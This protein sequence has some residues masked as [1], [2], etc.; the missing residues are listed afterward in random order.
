MSH[1]VPAAFIFLAALLSAKA[2]PVTIVLTGDSTVNEQGGWGTGFCAAASRQIR[3]INLALN[4][5]SSKSFRDEGRWAPV[6]A[7]KPNYVLIQFGHNDQ[8][9]KGPARETDPSTTYRANLERYIDEVRGV[10]GTPVLVTSIVRRNFDTAGRIKRDHL[11]PYV[12]AV[13][14]LA[15]KRKVPLI[16]LYALT[17]EQSEKLGPSGSAALGVMGADGKLDTTH[18]GPK[19]QQEIG[20]MAVREF[21]RLHPNL[22][23]QFHELVGWRD[24]VRQPASWFATEEAIRIGDNLLLY[25]HEA[26]GWDKNIDMGLPLGSKDRAEVERRKRTGHPGIDNGATYTQMQ[27]LAK[28][29]TATKHER[30]SGSFRRAFNYLLDA[31]YANGGWPQ[32]YPLRKG[33]YTHITY[34]DDAMGEVLRMLSAI[35]ESRPEYAF[36]TDSERQR[37]RRAVEKGIECILKTQVIVNSKLT[38]WCAQ[39]D[40]QTLAPAKAR[41]YELPS[42]S[43]SESVGIVRFLMQIEQPSPEVIRAVQAAVAWFNEAKINGIRLERKP[44]PGS[45]KGYDLTVV[46]DASAGPQWARFY[47]ILTNRPMFSGRDGIV[48]WQMSEI[49]YER[50]NGYRWYVDSPRKL[51]EED[52]PKWRAKNSQLLSR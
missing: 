15:A 43:G 11:I 7:E 47:E 24:A 3:C 41:S 39:H 4:G 30:F 37:A 12:E 38:V 42:L 25:Q 13:R 21:T 28:V 50:R 5:R 45:P 34:N 29:Y 36:L 33:Y 17:L 31:Q 52:Y 51:L 46:P 6:L 14:Q 20:M 18:L 49:E 9:G 8:P 32:F 35:A 1:C 16:D 22:R 2:D 40:E 10:G 26:G 27:Y 19:G 48:K 23:G 44:Q